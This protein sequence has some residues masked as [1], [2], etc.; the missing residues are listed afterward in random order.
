MSTV[1]T[2][3]FDPQKH[4]QDL[5]AASNKML[6]QEYE[7]VQ[8][9]AK[10]K[11]AA[12]DRKPMPADEREQFIFECLQRAYQTWLQKVL[13]SPQ[14]LAFESEKAQ[15]HVGVP[16]ML[17]EEI[18]AMAHEETDYRLS[19]S[20]IRAQA[21]KSNRIALAKRWDYDKKRL[22]P[23]NRAVEK[24]TLSVQS[25][26]EVEH[27]IH[28]LRTHYREASQTKLLDAVATTHK[29]V[30]KA[31]HVATGY[32][33]TKGYRNGRL[34]VISYTPIPQALEE[35][36]VFPFEDDNPKL[37]ELRRLQALNREVLEFAEG[38]EL[39]ARQYELDW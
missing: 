4:L 8:Q 1:A 11:K 3:Q 12:S 16:W 18:S 27:K 29:A 28:E 22:D 24:W 2:T 10:V 36:A 6:K 9:D 33:Y 31:I 20:M 32:Y 14:I 17:L 7:E 34:C 38:N 19:V 37:A 25:T 5:V 39:D 30:S 21:K 35:I 23:Y 26:K 13:D 15:Q